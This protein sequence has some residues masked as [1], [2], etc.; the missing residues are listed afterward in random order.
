MARNSSRGRIRL[1]QYLLISGFALSWEG[2]VRAGVLDQF[3]FARPTAVLQRVADWLVK[4]DVYGHLGITF[5]ESLLA[6]VIGTLAGIG[7]GLWLALTPTMLQV[8]EPFIKASNAIPRIV[9]A[10]IFTLWLGLGIASKVALGITLVFFLAFF[11]TYQGIREVNPVILAN[12][13]MLGAS[14]RHLLRHV[15][16]PSAAGWIISSL[17]S[18]IGFA[19]VGAVVG[20]Y[21]G[22]A[23]GIGYMIAQAEGLFDTTGVFAG[24][25]VLV[26]FV[27]ILDS[28]VS[29]IERRVLVWRPALSAAGYAA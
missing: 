5:A 12:A 18:S 13:R 26:A 2:L 11:N 20:E 14:W 21:L 25:A 10:P 17:R 6:F 23:S 7:I 19:V 22:A 15:Y 8:L 1:Y 16:L 3:F 24:M 28:G 29:L 4:G 27:L 9:L